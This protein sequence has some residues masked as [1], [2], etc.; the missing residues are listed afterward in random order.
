MNTKDCTCSVE[1][2][3]QNCTLHKKGLRHTLLKQEEEE[4]EL[5]DEEDE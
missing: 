4:T 3:E 2:N 5:H 1:N